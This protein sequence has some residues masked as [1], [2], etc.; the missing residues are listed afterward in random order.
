M[1]SDTMQYEVE[2]YATESQLRVLTKK[3][4]TELPILVKTAEA[5][6]GPVGKILG[7]INAIFGATNTGVGVIFKG[8]KK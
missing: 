4:K 8:G 5:Y 2:A 7:Y 3:I 1:K 6:K